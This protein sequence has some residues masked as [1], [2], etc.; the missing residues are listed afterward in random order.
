MAGRTVQQEGRT[1][2]CS[3]TSASSQDSLADAQTCCWPPTVAE[4][5]WV[6]EQQATAPLALGQERKGGAKALQPGQSEVGGSKR[7][8]GPDEP[9]KRA[10][11]R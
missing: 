10:A 1:N 8:A 7:A 4:H 5:A 6:L 11:V 2:G 3:G 9:T